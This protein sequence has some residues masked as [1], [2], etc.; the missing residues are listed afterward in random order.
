MKK[1]VDIPARECYTIITVRGGQPVDAGSPREPCKTP[2]TGTSPYR[3]QPHCAVYKWVAQQRDYGGVAVDGV[4]SPKSFIFNGRGIK[5]PC[6]LYF[7][8]TLIKFAHQPYYTPSHLRRQSAKYT[9]RPPFFF[10]LLA[11]L[12]I[13]KL[14]SFRYNRI[15]THPTL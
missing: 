15:G 1:S 8:L 2:R 13:D 12:P 4:G 3:A 7:S 5:I 6:P 14:I 11:I 10:L 9:K